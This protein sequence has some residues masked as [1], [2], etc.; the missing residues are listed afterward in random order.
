MAATEAWPSCGDL[1]RRKVS[2]LGSTE[3]CA[4]KHVQPDAVLATRD[5]RHPG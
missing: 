2:A 4:I 5:A 1:G 3:F